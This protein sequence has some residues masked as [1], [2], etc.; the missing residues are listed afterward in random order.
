ML[1]ARGATELCFSPGAPWGHW[2]MSEDIVIIMTRGLLASIGR[3]P[4]MLLHTPQHPGRPD[5]SSARIGRPN[6]EGWLDFILGGGETTSS[7]SGTWTPTCQRWRPT[8]SR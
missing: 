5:V 4:G 2:A 3:G 6:P 1:L 8:A 7:L